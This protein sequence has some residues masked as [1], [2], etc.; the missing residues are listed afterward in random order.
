MKV[1]LSNRWYTIIILCVLLISIQI[2]P[3][4]GQDGRG[5]TYPSWSPDDEYIAF[6][7]IENG[8]HQIMLIDKAGEMRT[9]TDAP[10]EGV[11]E[12]IRWSPDGQYLA[13]S[14]LSLV[15]E[16]IEIWIAPVYE[17]QPFI[18]TSNVEGLSRYP[19][20]S[21]DS[22]R[23]VFMNY[24]P[25]TSD[26]LV[27]PRPSQI[28]EI[29]IETMNA[30]QLTP[31]D[32][33][34]GEPQWLSDDAIVFVSLL[35]PG[36]EGL[37]RYNFNTEEIALIFEGQIFDYAVSPVDN[38]L[39]FSVFQSAV[40]TDLVLI[41]GTESESLVTD[42]FASD[43][44]WSPDGERLVMSIWCDDGQ[45]IALFDFEN[46][47]LVNVTGCERIGNPSWS[48]DSSA[49][50]YRDSGIIWLFNLET[51]GHTPLAVP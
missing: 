9:L 22:S 30:I 5:F 36:E 41:D 19:A 28:W 49:F 44:S 42:L 33:C 26:F 18:L 10:V 14:V 7:S 8:E 24:H 13:Y 21:Y 51:Q 45:Q 4:I 29:D 15:E 12:D 23:I 1:G 35:C 20:W 34:Y 37:Y 27:L 17:G 43:L 32:D 2:S 47:Q 50:A 11:V 40:I 3:V 16:K 39:V 25:E 31:D 48:P 38:R 46:H 6:A